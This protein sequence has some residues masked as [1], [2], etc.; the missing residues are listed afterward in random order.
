MRAWLRLQVD[1]RRR[2]VVDVTLYAPLAALV[3][4][5]IVAVGGGGIKTMSQRREAVAARYNE[6]RGG[7]RALLRDGRPRAGRNLSS[8]DY[9]DTLFIQIYS[10]ATAPSRQRAT[11]TMRAPL[12]IAPTTQ[13]HSPEA[14]LIGC[15][16]TFV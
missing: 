8:L 6:A 12:S 5:A 4:I 13:V 2:H 1:C 11:V 14:I 15:E 10:S 7:G 16:V 9:P 3:G